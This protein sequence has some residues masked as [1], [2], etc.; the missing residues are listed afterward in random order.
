MAL[1]E[2]TLWGIVPGEVISL[3]HRAN[4]QRGRKIATFSIIVSQARLSSCSLEIVIVQRERGTLSS[5]SSA[6]A[7]LR[8]KGVCEAPCFAAL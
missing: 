7:M 8:T 2:V 6:M 5:C 3:W 4:L 1:C